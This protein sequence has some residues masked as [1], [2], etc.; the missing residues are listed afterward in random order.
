VNL[1]AVRLQGRG[2]VG[3]RAGVAVL[4]AVAHRNRP[5]DSDL[6]QPVQWR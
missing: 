4:Q 2:R 5:R 1:M 6:P 3:S